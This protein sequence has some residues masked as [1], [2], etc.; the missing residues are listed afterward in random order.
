MNF[1]RKREKALLMPIDSKLISNYSSPLKSIV[2][3]ET[4]KSTAKK[5]L[6]THCKI[7]M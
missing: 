4:N 7:I 6:K 5:R 2:S 3:K 1:K